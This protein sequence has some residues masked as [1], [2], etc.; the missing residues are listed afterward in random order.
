MFVNPHIL[1]MYVHA[2]RTGIRYEGHLLGIAAEDLSQAMG[3][4]LECHLRA[5]ARFTS[6][7]TANAFTE[8]TTRFEQALEM[9]MPNSSHNC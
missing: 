4:S 3:H 5:N 2:R 8:A 6:N 1:S 7:E 9:K